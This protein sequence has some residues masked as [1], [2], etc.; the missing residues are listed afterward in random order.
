MSE[1]P[2]KSPRA[3]WA[4][5]HAELDDM[6]QNSPPDPEAPLAPWVRAAFGRLLIGD[7][8]SEEPALPATPGELSEAERLVVR[9]LEIVL[10]RL[11]PGEVGSGEPE[12]L[13]RVLHDALDQLESGR[14]IRISDVALC[15]RVDGFGSYVPFASTSFLAGR[16]HRVIVYT[17]V[18]SFAHRR[19]ETDDNATLGDRWAV[20][21]SQAVELYLDRDG[22][23]VWTRPAQIVRDTSRRKRRDFYLVDS[24]TLPANLSVGEYR[25]KVVM[26]DLT[27]DARDARSNP[28]CIVADESLTAADP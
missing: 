3:R 24:L 8:A 20:E 11:A 7:A 13:A 26:R 17:E 14:Q 25:L 12:A 5:L 2:T 19:I 10:P 4:R 18:E 27:T 23:P 21:L 28:A 22:T 16:P 15:T 1:V 6:I 9:A